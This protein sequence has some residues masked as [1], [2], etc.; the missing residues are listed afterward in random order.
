MPSNHI[1][2]NKYVF[3]G[4]IIAPRA[5]H[6]KRVPVVLYAALSHRD[7]GEAHIAVTYHRRHHV[8]G[9]VATTNERIGTGY[10]IAT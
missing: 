1:G 5:P 9:M 2:I 7:N 8:V 6:T 10:S 4:D 3:N